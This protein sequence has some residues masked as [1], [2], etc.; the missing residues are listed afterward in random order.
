MYV[1]VGDDSGDS[2]VRESEVGK[3][4]I[5]FVSSLGYIPKLC[6]VGPKVAA[7]RLSLPLFIV[8][9]LIL[10]ATMWGM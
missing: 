10:S 8:G 1:V 6:L 3:V 9:C 7:R 4:R 5:V 2:T